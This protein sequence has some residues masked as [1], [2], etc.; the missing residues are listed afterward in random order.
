[1]DCALLSPIPGSVIKVSKFARLIEIFEE[2]VESS[3][4]RFSYPIQASFTIGVLGHSMD[5][6]DD[7][8]FSFLSAKISSL[9]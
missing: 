4:V 1:M 6:V 7:S 3:F 8:V 5:V 2:L 9:V